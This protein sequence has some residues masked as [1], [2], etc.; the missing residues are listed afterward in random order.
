MQLHTTARNVS[1]YTQLTCDAVYLGDQHH[2]KQNQERQRSQYHSMLHAP[3]RHSQH[4]HVHKQCA[5]MSRH[6][7]LVVVMQT[8]SN[9]QDAQ[10]PSCHN[11]TLL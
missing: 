4:R 7:L 1:T 10:G 8:T 11:I 9:I 6:D 2:E 3:Y 5:T